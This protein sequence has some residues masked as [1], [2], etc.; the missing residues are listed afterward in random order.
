MIPSAT[1]AN[2]LAQSGLSRKLKVFGQC[3]RLGGLGGYR[4]WSLALSPFLFSSAMA[5]LPA[6][7][8]FA[9]EVLRQPP[10][11]IF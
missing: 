2:S 7:F 5:F 11:P 10:E 9:R 8:D 4:E 6:Q 3:A 1:S